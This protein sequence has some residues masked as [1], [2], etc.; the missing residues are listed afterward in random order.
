[1]NLTKLAIETRKKVKFFQNHLAK[2][3]NRNETIRNLTD[4]TTICLFGASYFL[5]FHYF[6]TD[7]EDF[8][9][10]SLPHLNEV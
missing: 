5:I 9:F 4:F 8:I 3:K 7:T 10:N 2:H 6:R 1:M